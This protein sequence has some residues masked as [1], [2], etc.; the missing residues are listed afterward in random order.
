MVG[1][2]VIGYG[3]WGPNIVRNFLA[4]EGAEVVAICDKNPGALR[5]AEGINHGT[6]LASNPMDVI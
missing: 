2:G 5:R 3:Y 6:R 1:V 4:V